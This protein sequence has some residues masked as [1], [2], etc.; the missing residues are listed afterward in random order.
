MPPHL[1]IPE[2]RSP[3]RYTPAT[4]PAP[5]NTPQTP[6][7]TPSSLFGSASKTASVTYLLNSL[8]TEIPKPNALL[9]TPPLK[10][11]SSYPI[12]PTTTPNNTME[13]YQ[14]NTLADTN[15]VVTPQ[16]LKSLV[17]DK[18]ELVGTRV[19]KFLDMCMR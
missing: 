8:S 10:S 6:Q 11:A 12:T 19:S 15:Y 5:S 16:I 7:P 13:D 3:P 9:H 4:P 18:P 17:K 14:K 2:I 1:H